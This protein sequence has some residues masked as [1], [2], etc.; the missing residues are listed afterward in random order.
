MKFQ[1]LV[2]SH[3]QRQEEIQQAHIKQYQEF[4]Q[5]WDTVLQKAQEEDQMEISDLENRQTQQ[6]GE[7]R[8]NLEETLPLTFKFS[9]ELLNLRKIQTNLAKQKDYQEAHQVQQQANEQEENERQ[10]HM[11]SRLKK[12]LAA[13]SKLMQKQQTE[14]SGLTKK[15]E[16]K[17]NEYLKKREQEHNQILQCYENS[18][19]QVENQQILE[20]KKLE[21]HHK[22]R[23]STAK[24]RSMMA[25][26]SASRMNSSR[27]G[28]STASKRN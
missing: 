10:Q 13:E 12:I 24:G 18:K 14:M 11:D 5:H 21:Q 7:N 25:S 22:T 2:F 17:M 16:G 27:M 28:R 20:R 6:L 15:L 9:A 8:Q 4:N 19:K 3:E 26:Q 23:P 1:H